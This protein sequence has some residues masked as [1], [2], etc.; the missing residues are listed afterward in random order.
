MYEHQPQP[1]G[2][3]FQYS[4]YITK[5]TPQQ[6]L[7]QLLLHLKEVSDMIAAPV[8]QNIGGNSWSREQLISYRR[9]LIKEKKELE[10]MAGVNIRRRVYFWQGVDLR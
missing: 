1:E 6:Q 10:Q 5:T 4:D 2:A 3:M 9:D 8:S 7:Q